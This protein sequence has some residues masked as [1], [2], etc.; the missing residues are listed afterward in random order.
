MGMA[1]GPEPDTPRRQVAAA[2]GLLAKRLAQY[3]QDPKSA[4]ALLHV[5]EAPLPVTADRPE[6]AAWTSWPPAAA[7]R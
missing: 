3:R 6:L 7:S 4:D 1:T 5:G 2:E